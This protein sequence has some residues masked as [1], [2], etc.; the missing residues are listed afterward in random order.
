MIN[1]IPQ[2]AKRRILIEYWFRVITVWLILWASAL[3]IGAVIIFPAYVLV[4]HQVSVYEES[5]AEASEKVASYEN[6]SKSLVQASQQAKVI[7]DES[8]V[9]IFSYYIKLIEGLQSEGIQVSKIKLNRDNGEIAPV[10]L[11]G[12]ARDRKTLASFRDRLLEEE[13][14]ISVDLPISNLAS[15]SD[16]NFT[17]TVV[18]ANK[19]SV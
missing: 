15:D 17:I 19:D 4:G 1:L 3:F 9:Q 11:V 18:L 8:E 12:V 13:Q 10:V 16:I 6:V 14:I 7:M 5:A 2:K